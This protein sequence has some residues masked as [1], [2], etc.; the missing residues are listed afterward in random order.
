MAGL[1]VTDDKL[2]LVGNYGA[3]SF[4]STDI[5]AL[6]SEELFDG[7]PPTVVVDFVGTV[8]SMRWAVEVLGTGG[9]LVQLT[10]FRDR[11]A[12]IT[13]R[14][15][16]FREISIIA[17]RYATRAE[18][19]EASELLADERVEAV[20]GKTVGPAGLGELHADLKAGRVLGRGAIDWARL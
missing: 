2:E 1:D 9:R 12:S 8:D 14:E 18:V 6:R 4:D 15:M 16:V 3:R 19:Q 17:S 5:T 20:I 11:V 13:S 7:E 10:T